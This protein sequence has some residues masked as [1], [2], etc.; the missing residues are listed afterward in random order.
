MI[1]RYLV[2]YLRQSGCNA[3][4]Q[5]WIETGCRNLK[6]GL[7]HPYR[8]SKACSPHL[9]ARIARR[10]IDPAKIKA[11]FRKMEKKFDCVVVEGIGGALVPY[12]SK[13]LVIDIAK[14]LNLPVL[15]VA[16]NK[17]GAINHILLTLEALESRKLEILGIIFNNLEEQDR[18]ILR[19]NPRIVEKL[20][21]VK[22]LGI[23]PWISGRK[24]I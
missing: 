1:C 12:N 2:R 3:V 6:I 18:T 21:K 15:L 5:K 16:G 11:S 8:F 17:L 19:D 9:A 23:F 14:E 7:G 13:N 4:Y 22:V 20:S 24:K 10:K